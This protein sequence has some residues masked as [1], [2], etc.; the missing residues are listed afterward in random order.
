MRKKINMEFY[1]V[2]YVDALAKH[3]SGSSGLASY[4]Q[5]SSN[6]SNMSVHAMFQCVLRQFGVKNKLAG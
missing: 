6:S 3:L 5:T 1:S 4:I 2:N